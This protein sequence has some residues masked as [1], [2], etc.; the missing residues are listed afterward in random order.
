MILFLKGN[1]EYQILSFCIKIY[2]C[3]KMENQYINV[4][5]CLEVK[6]TKIIRRLFS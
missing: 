4:C 2:K 1:I 5:W 6:I 3:I